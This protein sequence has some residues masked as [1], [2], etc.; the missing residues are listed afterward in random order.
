MEVGFLP[1][2][3]PQAEGRA[4]PGDGGGL[5]PLLW[6]RRSFEGSGEAEGKRTVPTGCEPQPGAPTVLGAAG[7]S[8][9]GLGLGAGAVSMQLEEVLQVTCAAVLGGDSGSSSLA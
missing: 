4:L 5:C 7:A 1:R 8:A 9:T 6:Q 2:V 3:N